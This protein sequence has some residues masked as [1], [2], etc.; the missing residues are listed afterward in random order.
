MKNDCQTIDCLAM[1]RQEEQKENKTPEAVSR[2]LQMTIKQ[3]EQFLESLPDA[4]II[5][6]REGKIVQVNA[7]L[8]QLFGYD[9]KELTG[10]KLEILMPMRFRVHHRHNFSEYISRP[11]IRPMGTGLELYGLKND[12]TEF[13]IDISLSYLNT[14]GELVAMAAVRDVTERKN[15]E[16]QIELNYRIQKTIGQVLKISLEP[17]PFEEQLTRVLDLIITTPGF[18]VHSRGSI[19]LVENEPDSLVLKA[20][21]GFSVAQV[22]SCKTVLLEKGL[23]GEGAS[24]CSS[25][26]TDC[27]DENREIHY[28]PRGSFG[29]YCVPIVFG[30]TT[31][32]LININVPDGRNPPQEEEFLTAIANSLASLI[33]RHQTETAQKNLSEQLAEAEKLASLGRIAANV[34]HTIKNPLTVIGGFAEKLHDN[35]PEGSKDKKFAGLIFTESIRLDRILRNVLLFSRGSAGLS[36]ACDLSAIVE[37][38]LTPYEELC[39]IRSILVQ[40]SYADVPLFDANREQVYQAV[41]NLISNAIDAMPGGGTLTVTTTIEKVNGAPFAVVSVKDTGA[42]IETGI[43]D[44]IFEPFYSTKV[45]MK[46]TGLGLS[47]AK[48]ITEGYGGFVRV[49]SKEGAGSTFSLHFPA[50]AEVRT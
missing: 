15:T 50:K 38:V 1:D 6:S 10:R 34:A 8:E 25:V 21:H 45:A 41:E 12:G 11:R 37:K 36:E 47:I 22:D 28:I 20:M 23:S 44:K 42:G 2:D 46:G 3:Y 7:Q 16:R 26:V 9:R 24:A 18:A 29:Q 5:V 4:M 35:L 43:L 32:G 30:D 33:E 31:L 39:G 49:N 17:I 19:Y 13:P 14:G 27:L 48:K 40:K